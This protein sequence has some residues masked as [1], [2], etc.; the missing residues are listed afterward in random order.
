[1][2]KGHRLV[3]LLAVL[4][5][6]GACQQIGGLDGLTF[7]ADHGGSMAGA[8]G[9]MAGAAGS[10]AGAGSGP[11]CA[12]P[13]LQI[14]VSNVDSSAS[15]LA[16][17][18]VA[19]S[20]APAAGGTSW[21]VAH[22]DGVGCSALHVFVDSVAGKQWAWFK[23]A[24]K[25]APAA[26]DNNYWLYAQSPPDSE[27]RDVFEFYDEAF[28]DSDWS[29]DGSVTDLLPAGIRI[30]G[31]GNGGTIVSRASH[32]PYYAL[33]FGMT[34]EEPIDNGAPK[35]DT[36]WFGGGLQPDAATWPWN[37]WMSRVYAPSLLYG[38]SNKIKGSSPV[39]VDTGVLHIYSL[40]RLADRV[41]YRYDFDNPSREVVVSDF[42]TRSP[43]RFSAYAGSKIVVTFARLRLAGLYVPTT[44]LL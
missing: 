40:E 29:R 27:A 3:P 20:T 41:V 18:Q 14:Q 32:Y 37:L 26:R 12:A 15:L 9:S 21:G 10:E 11:I 24:D 7:S 42:P 30:D 19:L 5:A 38:E 34:V 23:I 13:A 36:E 33:D 2:L 4:A 31:A 22:F 35:Q 17:F 25:I 39:G 1:M 28:S 44:Q 6:S 8:A 16:G 43:I